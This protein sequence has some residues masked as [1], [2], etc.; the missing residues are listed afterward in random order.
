VG[1]G[2]QSTF[3]MDG[4][5]SEMLFGKKKNDRFSEGDNWH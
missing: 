4:V 1:F 5:V 2:R 3:L